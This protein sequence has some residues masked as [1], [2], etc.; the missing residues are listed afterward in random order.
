MQELHI[1][2]KRWGHEVVLHNSEKYC[3]KLLVFDKDMSGSMHYHLLKQ[4]TWCVNRGVFQ[5]TWIDKSGTT[6]H[7]E[8]RIGDVVTIPPG[9]P[10]QLKALEESEIFEASTQ[11][12]D[13][14][15]YRIWI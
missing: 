1:V 9:Q 8:L 10:H 3:A 2:K 5:Y 12:F 11:H 7:K 4:E 6:Y 14:D 15:T 13:E